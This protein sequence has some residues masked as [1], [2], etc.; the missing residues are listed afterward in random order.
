MEAEGV[1]YIIATIPRDLKLKPIV[2]EALGA[3]YLF[4]LLPQTPKGDNIWLQ[5]L[6][7]YFK[8]NR[9]ILRPIIVSKQNYLD[10]LEAIKDWEGHSMKKVLVDAFE[11]YME[12]EPYWLVELSI[13]ELFPANKRKIGEVL[14]RGNEEFNP[15]TP[16]DNFVMAR[17]P[18]YF[19]L[20]SNGSDAETNFE[21]IPSEINGHVE[22][23]PGGLC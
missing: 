6:E 23:Y 1:V 3:H 14:I 20:Y 5:R 7:F 13:P 19:V 2:A 8:W 17:L 10:H 9:L 16:F 12:D 18:K 11:K 22:L 4:S 15:S 21:F